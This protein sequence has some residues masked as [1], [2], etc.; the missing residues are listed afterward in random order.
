M[1]P[2][3]KYKAAIFD[4]DGTL[5]DSRADISAAL[6]WARSQSGLEELPLEKVLP[7][8]GH[9]LPSLIKKGFADSPFDPDTKVPLAMEHYLRHPCRFSSLYPGVLE[10]L[11]SLSIPMAIVSNKPTQLIEPVLQLTSLKP[12]FELRF[13]GEDF[14]HRKPH[15]AA[16]VHCCEHWNLAPEQVLMVGDMEPDADFAKNAGMKFAF[17]A[18]GYSSQSIEAD[19][20]LNSFSECATLLS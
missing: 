12:H 1:P 9:G 5:I 16:A 6:N 19:H 2:K 10:T 15:P 14:P 8:I 17:C 11:A 4:L 13:G 18:Y 7:M 20:N 3:P